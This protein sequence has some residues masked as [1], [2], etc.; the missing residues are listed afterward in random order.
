[1]QDKL[2]Q[3]K[4][5]AKPT[6]PTRDPQPKPASNG[7]PKPTDPRAEFFFLL[8]VIQGKGV[9]EAR[10]LAELA[11]DLTAPTEDTERTEP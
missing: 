1:M 4:N 8:G 7:I 9:E 6:A 11:I 5:M 10:R 3:R 2:T